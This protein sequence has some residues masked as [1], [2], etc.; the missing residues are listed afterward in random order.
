[1]IIMW[2]KQKRR[3]RGMFKVGNSFPANTRVK[4]ARKFTFPC[5]FP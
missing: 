5:H 3:S 1:M 4:Q 2:V